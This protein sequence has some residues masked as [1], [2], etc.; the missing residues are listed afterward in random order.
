MLRDRSTGH[1]KQSLGLWHVLYHRLNLGS[2]RAWR[3]RLTL[4]TGGGREGLLLDARTGL[5]G[6]CSS[7]T[8]SLGSLDRDSSTPRQGQQ[9][10]LL[11]GGTAAKGSIPGLGTRGLA[12]ARTAARVTVPARHKRCS[13]GRNS[14]EGDNRM[15]HLD[16]SAREQ[17][18]VERVGVDVALEIDLVLVRDMVSDH[19]ILTGGRD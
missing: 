1:G 2:R 11:L 9:H 12:S 4:A 18:L 15:C 8:L 10:R 17:G 7:T 19:K 5:R 14:S 16:P 13:V 6:A 3:C